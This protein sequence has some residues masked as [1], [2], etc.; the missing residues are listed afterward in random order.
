MPWWYKETKEDG[1]PALI[2]PNDTE[3]EAQADAAQ[4]AID[5]PNRTYDSPYEAD[6]GEPERFPRPRANV[7]SGDGYVEAWDDG[8]SYPLT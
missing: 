1:R 4:R 2:G 8:N 7:L 5:Y 3:S 6:D